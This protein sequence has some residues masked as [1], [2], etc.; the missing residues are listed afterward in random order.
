MRRLL[1]I[2]V[3]AIALGASS[4]DAFVINDVLAGTPVVTHPQRGDEPFATRALMISSGD[5]VTK[6]RQLFA[7]IAR[8]QSRMK[9][10]EAVPAR[11]GW[12]TTR[13]NGVIETAKKFSGRARLEVVNRLINDAIVYKSDIVDEWTSPLATFADGGDCEDYAIAKYV[14]LRETGWADEDLRVTMSR[15]HA[16]LA[17]RLNGKWLILDSEIHHRNIV[18]DIHRDNFMPVFGFNESAVRFFV[19]AP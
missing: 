3:A 9:L 12:S 10:C 7:D 6:W 19:P 17:A 14:A 15:S 11:C 16:V 8:D 5:R 13:F 18:E 4:A 2:T 1:M